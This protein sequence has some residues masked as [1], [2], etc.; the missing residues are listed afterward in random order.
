M[1][2]ILYNLGPFIEDCYRELGV[3]E[4]SRIT[5]ITAPTSSERLKQ[6]ESEGLLKKKSDRGYLLFR[7]NRNSKI[8]L[9]LSR[10]YWREKLKKLIEHLDSIFHNPTIILFGSLAKLEA[11][12]DSDI[13]LAI[14]TKSDK[15][16]D[17]SKYEKQY[18][19]EVQLF[20]F[21][22]LGKINKELKKN[23]INGYIV[24]GELK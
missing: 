14:L 2:K 6:F 3:R 23:I 19:R 20:K 7:A 9:D 17:L 8:L 12:K 24:Q 4:Y 21:D 16:T 1:L 13:D 15:K 10:A 22:S 11:K 5:N 18:K